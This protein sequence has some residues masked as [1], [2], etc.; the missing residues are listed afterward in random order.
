MREQGPISA[1]VST[2]VVET[3]IKAAQVTEWIVEW[4]ASRQKSLARGPPADH[5]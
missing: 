2:S 5:T 3:C 1:R 4:E